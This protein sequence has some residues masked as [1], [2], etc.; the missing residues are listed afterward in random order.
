MKVRTARA[1]A[2]V[3]P[4]V[5][6]TLA[7][8]PAGADGEPRPEPRDRE[9]VA[10]LDPVKGSGVHGDGHAEVEFDQ[11]GRIDEFEVVAHGLL[12]DHP[13][14][15]HIHFGEQARHEC[16]TLKD[17][18]SG[19]RRLT[20]TEGAPA[21]GPVVLSLTTEGD[22]SPASV[23]AI[24]RYDTA[25]HGT[26]HYERDGLFETADGVAEAIADGQGVVVIHGVDYNRDGTYSGEAVSDLAPSLPTEATDP[27]MCG[28]LENE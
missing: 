3:V 18:T 21:Y 5:G 7:A 12:A 8:S 22:T 1:L 9:V 10:D 6:L 15:A 2:L 4:L 28:V 13:H 24:E 27:A 26:V 25:T 19:D 17:D 20:T 11:Q 14:A 16:P 23:L